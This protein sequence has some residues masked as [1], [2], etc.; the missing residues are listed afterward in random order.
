MVFIFQIYNSNLAKK[1][2]RI[3]TYALGYSHTLREISPDVSVFNSLISASLKKY[4]I[5][6]VMSSRR[7]KIGGSFCPKKFLC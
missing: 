2:I 5:P 7:N 6:M 1:D 4:F 3:F